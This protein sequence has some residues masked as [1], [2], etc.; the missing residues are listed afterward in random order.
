ME[1]NA[2]TSKC[3]DGKQVVDTRPVSTTGL[4]TANVNS[5]RVRSCVNVTSSEHRIEEL[6]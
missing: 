2:D 4:V 1:E 5:P 3:S 6:W